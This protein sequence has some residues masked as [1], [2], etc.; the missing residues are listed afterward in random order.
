M[1]KKTYTEDEIQKIINAKRKAFREFDSKP[2]SEQIRLRE[3]GCDPHERSEIRNARKRLF[4]I[5]YK[6]SL[7]IHVRKALTAIGWFSDSDEIIT[8]DTGTIYVKK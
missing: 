6:N 3:Q 7:P 8:R 1:G 5:K 4:T 2:V